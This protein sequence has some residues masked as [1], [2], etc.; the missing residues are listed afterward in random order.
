MSSKFIITKEDF[1]RKDTYKYEKQVGNL[2]DAFGCGYGAEFETLTEKDL[3]DLKNGKIFAI[4]VNGE[5]VL[6]LRYKG[7]SE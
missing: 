5:Y 3:I 7:D 4:D 6:F 1:E 2:G